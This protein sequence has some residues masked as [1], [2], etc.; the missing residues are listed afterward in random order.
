MNLSRKTLAVIVTAAGVLTAGGLTGGYALAAANT[1]RSVSLLY[2]CENGTRTLKT[3]LTEHAQSCPVGMTEVILHTAA[4]TNGTQGP[5]GPVG[6]QGPQ[7]PKGDTGAAGETLVSQTAV[8]GATVATGGPFFANRTDLVQINVPNGKYRVGV[9]IK[10]ANVGGQTDRI[11]P[12]I[13]IYNG[14]PLSNFSNDLFNLGEGAL[15]S[16]A[17]IDQYINGSEI[18]TV[19]NGQIDVE[20]FGYDDPTRGAGSYTVEGGTITITKV[21]SA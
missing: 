18:V 13:A 19:T 11:F 1:P 5:Q 4:S 8:P 3:A 2:S 6:P 10:V 21:V 9:D 15:P 17:A 20:G 7:G 16:I 12:L 14:V